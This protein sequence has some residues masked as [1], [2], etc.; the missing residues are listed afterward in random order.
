MKAVYNIDV[1]VEYEIPTDQNLLDTTRFLKKTV[2]NAID[3]A[4]KPRGRVV[5]MT[6]KIITVTIEPKD[7]EEAK[8]EP[9]HHI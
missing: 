1:S 4:I 2:K 9:P 5:N 7:H 8:D 6:P 3:E